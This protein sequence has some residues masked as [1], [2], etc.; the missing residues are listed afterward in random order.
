LGDYLFHQLMRYARDLDLPVQLHTGH[1]AGIRNRVDKANAAHLAS[2][3][4]LH[5]R[6]QFD[7]FHGNWPYM[8]DVLFLAKNYPNVRLNLC[9]L[10]LIDPLYAVEFLRRA[11]MTVPHVKLHAFGGDYWDAPEYTVAHLELAREVV[12][13]A[14][15]DLV[16]M[17]WLEEPE[18][19]HLAAAWLYDNPNAYYR[20]GLPPL[21]S[22]RA[23]NASGS[24]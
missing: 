14:L 23:S 11:V 19:C 18:A 17:G 7:L 3:L 8:G 5:T 21:A 22:R 15:T 13:A 1:M 10:P 20:L 12:A 2:V 16:E 24:R 6:V 4:E 9:W